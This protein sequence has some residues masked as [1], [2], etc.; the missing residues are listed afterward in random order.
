MADLNKQVFKQFSPG[1][2]HLRLTPDLILKEMGYG[3]VQPEDAVVVLLNELFDEISCLTHPL[4]VYR[5]F[6][7]EVEES[8]V[9][10][11]DSGDFEVGQVIAS[12]LKGSVRFALFVG[13]AGNEFQAYQNKLKEEGDVLKMFM[14]DA[15]GSC[16][17]E[18]VGD[19]LESM[20]EKEIAPEYH[21]NRFSPGYCG[22][23]LQTQQHL[24]QLLEGNPCGVQ[25]S[26][27]SLM[28]PV[29]SISGIIGIGTNVNRKVYGCQY[30]ELETCYKRKNKK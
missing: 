15:I 23:Q 12:L 30:C 17:A 16:I 14:V 18:A 24:F 5:I 4:A 10:L 20:L 3:A 27:V 28:N 19:Y 9:K 1:F 8:S 6:G 2:E 25:L 29:K 22:W 21:T 11:I 13:T 7:G 26:E